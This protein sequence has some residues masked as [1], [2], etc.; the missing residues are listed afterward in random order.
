MMTR[1]IL[2]PLVGVLILAGASPLLWAQ[3]DGGLRGTVKDSQGGVLPG[4]T[5]TARS[6]E[7][8]APTVAV[9]DESGAYRLVNLPPGTYSI[10]AELSGF[11]TFKREGVLLR[12]GATFQVDITMEVGTLAETIT[13]TSDSPMIEVTAPSNVLNIDADFQKEV[14]VVASHFWSDFL[15]YTPGVLSRP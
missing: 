13:V 14:P 12:A 11:S 3:G 2:V 15:Q 4:V 7:M 8:I 6:P 9:T 1:R 10:T 5:V